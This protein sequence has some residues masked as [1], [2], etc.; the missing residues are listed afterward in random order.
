MAQALQERRVKDDLTYAARQGLVYHLWWHPHNFGTNL[1]K[2]V[3]MLRRILDDFQDLRE[4]YGM[5]SKNMAESTINN[6][7]FQDHVVTEE[8]RFAR[9]RG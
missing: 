4:R 2:N 3:G 1:E 9:P 8:D 5:Q 7:E 6:F